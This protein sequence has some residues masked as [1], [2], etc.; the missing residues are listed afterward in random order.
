M[1]LAA[2]IAYQP[3]LIR[4]AL[5][6]SSAT[7]WPSCKV[8][9]QRSASWRYVSRASCSSWAFESLPSFALVL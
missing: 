7:S 5:V 9:S 4:S 3:R 6:L 1:P 8:A 2:A